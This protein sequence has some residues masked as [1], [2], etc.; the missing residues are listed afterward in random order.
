MLSGDVV[1][2]GG[3]V[4]EGGEEDGDERDSIHDTWANGVPGSVKMR[5]WASGR[6]EGIN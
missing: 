4:V 6:L 1:M 3:P 5:F 2:A